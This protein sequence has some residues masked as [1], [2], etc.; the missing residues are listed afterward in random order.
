MSRRIEDEGLREGL[1]GD[2]PHPSTRDQTYRDNREA[3]PKL[4]ATVEIPSQ[5]LKPKLGCELAESS[6]HKSWVEAGSSSGLAPLRTWLGVGLGARGNS[7]RA[8]SRCSRHHSLVSPNFT[9]LALALP[10]TLTLTL[11]SP[12]HCPISLFNFSCTSLGPT[13]YHIKC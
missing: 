3:V 6:N 9:S 12:N 7:A 8:V 11:P 10:L 13:L 1:N 5:S 4:P 2:P